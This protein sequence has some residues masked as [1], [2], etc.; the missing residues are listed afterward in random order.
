MCLLACKMNVQAEATDLISLPSLPIHI[1]C[2]DKIPPTPD[3]VELGACISSTLSS[4]PFIPALQKDF[5]DS[6]IS[7]GTRSQTEGSICES[8]RKQQTPEASTAA[9]RTCSCDNEGSLG[10]CLRYL[11]QRT[12]EEARS[13]MLEQAQLA[14]RVLL[15]Q[16]SEQGSAWERFPRRK[17]RCCWPKSGDIHDLPFRIRFE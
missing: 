11:L 2:A 10:S 15:D 3:S 5:V 4:F 12:A 7:P 14:M 13:C 8:L 17:Y 6:A 16:C 9:D 1:E